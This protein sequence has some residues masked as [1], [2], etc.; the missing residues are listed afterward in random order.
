[1]SVFF[2]LVY[3]IGNILD[4][5]SQPD[6]LP[7]PSVVCIQNSERLSQLS[8]EEGRSSVENGENISPNE[9]QP[10]RKAKI[11][12]RRGP[13]RARGSSI[14]SLDSEE[15]QD[16]SEHEL[17]SGEEF[18]ETCWR[19]SDD[20]SDFD[21]TDSEDEEEVAKKVQVQNKAF[22]SS[23]SNG[24]S[25][26]FSGSRENSQKSSTEAEQLSQQLHDEER[27]TLSR[28][29]PI[30]EENQDQKLVINLEQLMKCKNQVEGLLVAMS[31]F[32]R[33]L[34][35]CSEI[36]DAFAANAEKI[37]LEKLC[38][39]LTLL[40]SSRWWDLL[41]NSKLKERME[42][43]WKE[44]L[45][46]D[47]HKSEELFCWELPEDRS[48]LGLPMLKGKLSSLLIEDELS[49]ND[50]VSLKFKRN[51]FNLLLIFY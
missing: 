13:R 12:T 39:I 23:S 46:E 2:Q 15:S 5:V 51:G 45:N 6:V 38:T 32:I 19:S 49:A 43:E 31:P 26:S 48:M 36:K 14:P 8:Q 35:T 4:E 50:K 25:D 42:R 37:F 21:F 44:L 27:V 7:P 24:K 22:D 3:R 1:M 28:G 41:E 11:G 30:V 20:E 18:L 47:N 40:V 16:D 34:Q 29:T 9:C 10:K 17:S 33:C